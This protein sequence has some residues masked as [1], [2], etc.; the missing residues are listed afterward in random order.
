VLAI[1]TE[2]T[3]RPIFFQSVVALFQPTE[4]SI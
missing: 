3:I 1:V 2:V 4:P